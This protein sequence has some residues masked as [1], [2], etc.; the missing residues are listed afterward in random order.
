MERAPDAFVASGSMPQE[1]AD[2]LASQRAAQHFTHP[3]DLRLWMIF[4][5]FITRLRMLRPGPDVL[6]TDAELEQVLA[7]A[8]EPSAHP[9]TRAA[10]LALAHELRQIRR[11]SLPYAPL[12]EGYQA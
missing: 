5:G 12:D 6:A 9:G 1:W 4:D 11:E 10:Q 2:M 8:T 3:S 7:A